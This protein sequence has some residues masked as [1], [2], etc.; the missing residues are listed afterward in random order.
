[1][2]D[3]EII[4]RKRLRLKNYD[5][6]SSAYYFITICTD[7]Q[8]PVFGSVIETADNGEMSLNH[9]GK[10]LE[11][12]IKKISE[13]YKKVRVNNYVIMP[14][15]I[16]MLFELD[17]ENTISI[18]QI[19]GLFKSGVSRDFGFSVWQRSFYDRVVR[20]EKEYMNI[21]EYIDNNPAQ[22]A[23]DKYYR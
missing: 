4:T 2:M 23:M 14:N 16:H 15:H 22:W 8:R 6:S 20:D 3:E 17:N 19:I 11:K 7:K 1:M 21:W 12:H 5:Y 10:Q 9:Y 13:R 18:S